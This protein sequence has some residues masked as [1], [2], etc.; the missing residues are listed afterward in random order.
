MTPPSVVEVPI[1]PELEREMKQV[2]KRIKRHAQDFAER[3]RLIVKAA[4]GGASQREIARIFDLTQ[5]G[6]RDIII[7]RTRSES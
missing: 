6:V 1:D 7:R 4:A 3:D 2:A 5:P